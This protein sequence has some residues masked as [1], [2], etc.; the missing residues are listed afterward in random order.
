MRATGKKRVNIV[1]MGCSK[2]LVDSE[3]LMARFSSAGW[4]VQFDATPQNQDLVIIN[5]CGFIH[6]A[7]EESVNTILEFAQSKLKGDTGKLCIIGCLSERYREELKIEIPEAD[8]ILGVNSVDQI[9]KLFD[10]GSA[11]C[12]RYDRMLS[13]PPHYAY[14]KISEGCD[15]KCSFCII[16]EI[17]GKHISRPVE[18]LVEE[19]GLLFDKGVRELILVAQDLTSYGTD[20]YG[21]N[22]LSG[23]L[24][25]LI[26]VDNV[27][28][29]RLHYAFPAGFPD[30]IL[31][32][33][34]ESG[35]ICNYLDIPFQHISDKMLRIMRRGSNKEN[36][37]RLINKIRT[38]VPGV[39]LRTTLLT[40]HPGETVKD[41]EELKEFVKTSRFERL[42]VFP[43]SHEENTYSFNRYRDEISEEE[44]T[45][46]V[47]ELMEMQQ[48]ISLELNRAKIGEKVKVLVDR[49][50]ENFYYGRTEHD[51]PEVDNEIIINKY[52]PLVT[53]NFYIAKI[54][55]IAEFDLFAEIAE[56]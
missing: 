50:D 41:F 15:R 49:E 40:G 31:D 38:R 6:D 44:K 48:E 2:N 18:T 20:L 55:E 19:A 4:Q 11:K 32:L 14:L 12:S 43:Y 28:W 51:S 3:S 47:S 22:M 24:D 52:R 29:I 53:G 1:T 23:L 54:T 26:S 56:Y 36:T 25:K 33:M 8:L 35:K 34:R 45:A 17:R 21:K 13:T 30:E 5:T 39:A 27:E 42:G 46:R 37:L 9:S 16:P 10:L 7:K